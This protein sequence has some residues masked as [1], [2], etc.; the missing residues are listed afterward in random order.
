MTH[1]DQSESSAIQP[2]ATEQPVGLIVGL[3]GGIGCGKTAVS[4]RF[5]LLGAA[6]VDADEISR[7][8]TARDGAAIPLIAQQFG[9]HLITIDGALDRAAMRQLVFADQQARQKLEAIVHPLVR[10]YSTQQCQSAL[11]AGAPYVVLSVPL[12]F[13][14]G[15][16]RARCHRVLVVDCSVEDQV[17]RVM[18]R[19][20]LSR[21]EVMAIVTAQMDRQQRLAKA[22]DVIDN[23]GDLPAL[24]TQVDALHQRYLALAA[25]L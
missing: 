10:E 19:S 17:Q 3:T 5:A 6:I 18:R 9:P 4:D 13:E 14:S 8:L 2:F 12:L 1:I 15:N 23:H 20:G 11:L 16:Y 21:D 22:D 24:H 25:A 7:A